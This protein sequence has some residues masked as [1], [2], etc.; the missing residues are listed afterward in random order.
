MSHFQTS[1]LMNQFLPLLSKICN[2]AA[3]WERVRAELFYDWWFT[4]NQFVLATSPSRLTTSNFIFR[5]NTCGHNPYVTSSL[6]TG[7]IC[8][9]QLLLGL[10]SEFRGTHDYISFSQVRDSPNLEGPIPVFTYSPGTEWPSY[11]SRHWV[12]FSLPSTAR[13]ATVEVSEPLTFSIKK[14]SFGS[15][16]LRAVSSGT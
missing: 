15:Q 5:L 2:D 11:T 8:R 14:E 6:T 4:T 1:E 10:A 12:P 9:L 13:R 3:F 7:W 16:V